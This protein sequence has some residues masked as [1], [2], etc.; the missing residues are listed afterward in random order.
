MTTINATEARKTL[1]P[2]LRQV[3]DDH[4]PVRITSKQ[5]NGVLMSEEDYD[6]WQE[7]MFLLRSRTNTMRLMEAIQ[8]ADEGGGTVRELID[9]DDVADAAA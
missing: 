1:Y 7:T 9:V 2:L 8:E 5:G 6:S 4:A 3:N